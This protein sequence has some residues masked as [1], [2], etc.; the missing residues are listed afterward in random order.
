MLENIEFIIVELL[1]ILRIHFAHIQRESLVSDDQSAHLAHALMH[2][3][4]LP[5]CRFHK[6]MAD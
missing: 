6:D 2:S 1:Q 5:S 3:T 4:F